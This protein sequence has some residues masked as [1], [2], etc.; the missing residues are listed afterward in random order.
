[1]GLD[2]PHRAFIARHTGIAVAMNFAMGGVMAWLAFRSDEDVTLW[3]TGGF[4]IDIVATTIFLT[5]FTSFFV[6][7]AASKAIQQHRVR[8]IEWPTADVLFEH[9]R[10]RPLLGSTGVAILSAVG[11]C[12]VVM[13]AFAL[14]DAEVV[15][16]STIVA[17]KAVYS[18]LLAAVVTPTV[19]LVAWAETRWLETRPIGDGPA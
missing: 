8:P 13:T 1:M 6:S 14:V 17:F 9:L 2:G 12:P 15:G 4:A 11:I 19:V 10:P 16:L 5:F 3:G 18:A 7:K